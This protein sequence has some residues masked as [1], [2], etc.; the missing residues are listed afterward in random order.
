MRRRIIV[1]IVAVTTAAVV[2]FGIPLAIAIH[3]L[4][5]A[6]ARTRL[7][8]EATLAARDI[9]T[10]FS[11]T[12]DPIDLPSNTKGITLGLYRPTGERISGAGPTTGDVSVLAAAGNKIHDEEIGKRLIAAV[13]V[14]VNEQVVA[15]VRAETSL[16]AA[17]HRTRLAWALMAALGVVVIAMAA[18]LAGVVA[19]RLTRPLRR[20]RDGAIRLGHGD[21]SI[22]VPPAGVPELDDLADALS[23]TAHRLGR[24]MRREQD[25]AT[26]ASH[27]LRTPLAGLR[28]TLE[29]ELAA[30]RPD[31]ALAL[32]ECL[33]ITDRLEG[34]V[35]D[36]LRLARE[37]SRS[38]PLRVDVIIE[39]VR[40]QWHGTLAAHG[41]RL[42]LPAPTP[43]DDVRASNA[44]IT[45]ALDVLMDNATRHGRGTVTIAC[46]PVAGGLTI[47]VTDEGVVTTP[48]D[49]GLDRTSLRRAR[50]HGIG[51][52]LAV[53]L[54][55][56]EGGRL[57]H[58][59]PGQ[60]ATF[61][62]VLPTVGTA[63]AAT[64]T[65]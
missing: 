57:L 14:A 18:S 65:D 35:T 55:E 25:F 22:T 6:E 41:R 26:H 39:H 15:V 16:H 37:P 2:L 17:E 5:I 9:P 20:V 27:Q 52:D 3:H 42:R 60:P 64:A 1:A 19:N 49:V 51:L 21:F 62:I 46:H 45:Q 54:V 8:H 40:T 32:D 31:P 28:V 30:P 58:P 43:T 38:K 24:A 44:A 36:L 61:S 13:P 10:D 56:A 47:T 11:S 50:G 48:G 23:S 29:A 63:T 4:Y 12:A 34:T 7:E 53:T 33:A 59:E